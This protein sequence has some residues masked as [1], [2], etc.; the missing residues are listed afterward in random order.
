MRAHAYHQLYNRDLAGD[1]VAEAF[2]RA[3]KYMDKGHPNPEAWLMLTLNRIC[4]AMNVKEWQQ[5]TLRAPA[6]QD[7]DTG[8]WEVLPIDGRSDDAEL[9]T[10]YYSDGLPLSDIADRLGTT[11]AIVKKRLYRARQRFK[12]FLMGG[13]P[14]AGQDE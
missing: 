14:G 1:A 10:L 2:T 8:L 11:P 12:L 4:L 3:L 9:L 7:A 13:E 5:A 6:P